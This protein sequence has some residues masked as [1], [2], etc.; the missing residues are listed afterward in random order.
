MVPLV[1]SLVPVLLAFALIAL[2][3]DGVFTARRLAQ[4]GAAALLMG[5]VAMTLLGFAGW[6]LM[7]ALAVGMLTLYAA[8]RREP[9]V[10]LAAR[11]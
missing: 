10:G 9:L 6:L 7:V 4:V 11:E 3:Y 2:A 8:H 1:A 5:P